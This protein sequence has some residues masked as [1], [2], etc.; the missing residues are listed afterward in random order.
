MKEKKEV[1]EPNTVE[2]VSFANDDRFGK[3]MHQ[4]NL[5]GFFEL[6]SGCYEHIVERFYRGM[7]II[8]ELNDTFVTMLLERPVYITP[9]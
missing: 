9:G 1:V 5:M 4:Q 6:S 3:W 2:L 7:L 8:E